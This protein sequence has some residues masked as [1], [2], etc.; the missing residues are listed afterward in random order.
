M[1]DHPVVQPRDR[2]A[3]GADEQPGDECVYEARQGGAEQRDPESKGVAL[4]LQIG[5]SHRS[6][7]VEEKAG[8]HRAPCCI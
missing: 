3:A 7:V 2:F 5:L 1:D 8:E 4:M 6:W